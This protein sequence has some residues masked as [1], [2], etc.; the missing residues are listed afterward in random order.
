MTSSILACLLAIWRSSFVN[1]L[2]KLFVRFSIRLFV[3]FFCLFYFVLFCFNG[4]THDTWKFLGQG[5]NPSHSYNLH[6]SCGSAGSFNPLHQAGDQTHTST[7]NRT[8]AVMFLTH[9]TTVGTPRLSVFFLCFFFFLLVVLLH[10]L[11]TFR[12]LSLS[13]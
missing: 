7:G 12:S 4:C 8:A 13:L 3:W 1:G 6:C 5:L 2:F 11:G 9:C 10:C